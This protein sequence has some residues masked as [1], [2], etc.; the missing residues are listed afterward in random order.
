MGPR[1]H[2]NAY[3]KAVKS[4]PF[5]WGQ[6]DCL[7]FTNDA[8][9]AMY[10]EGWA[11]DWLSR[12]MVNDRPMR[13]NE[14]MREFRCSDFGKAVDKRLQ[15][16]DCVPPLGALV[17]TKKARKWVTGVAIGIC[18]GSKCAFLDKVGVIYLPLDDIDGAWIKT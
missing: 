11:D 13:R 16:V 12:Y 6:H 7:T 14:L 2:L 18:T 15:R 3:L 4:K 9:T 5:V 17:T 10:G 1:E 8:F